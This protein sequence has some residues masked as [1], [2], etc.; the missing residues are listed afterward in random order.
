MKP[1]TGE[2]NQLG[3]CTLDQFSHAW[4]VM[5]RDIVQHHHGIALTTHIIAQYARL[6]KSF[7][8]PTG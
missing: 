6:D 5:L 1:V 2:E 7:V 3:T 4:V 8:Y